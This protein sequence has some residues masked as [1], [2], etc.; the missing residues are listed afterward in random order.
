MAE[1]KD[2][3]IC[4]LI[5]KLKNDE[6]L[7]P[8]MQ[9]DFVW[10]TD[11]ICDLF[12]SILRD[13]PIGTFLFWDV[14]NITFKKY[15]FNKFLCDVSERRKG[16]LVRGERSLTQKE[17]Y[18]TVL[19]GQQRITK[20]EDDKYQIAFQSERDIRVN[21]INS[22]TNEHE[23][24][25]KISE[26]Y[27]K[28]N[29]EDFDLVDYQEE[30]ETHAA[31]NGN[32]ITWST[33]ERRNFR[34]LIERFK[35]AFYIKP[36]VNYY[37]AKNMDLGQVVEIF[38]RVNSGGQKLN[39]SDLMLSVASAAHE[40]TMGEDFHVKIQ[41]AIDQVNESTT[42]EDGGFIADQDTILTTGLMIIDAKKLSLNKE[43]N[44]EVATL[45]KMISKW[46]DII[47]SLC[48]S[49]RYYEK[50]GFE[51]KKLSKNYIM[52]VAYYLYLHKLDSDHF[53]KQNIRA[54]CDRV[55]I[56]QWTL[57]SMINGLFNYGTRNILYKIKECIKVA[58]DLNYYPL[59]RLF[60]LSANISLSISDEQIKNDIL[61][62]KYGDVRIDPLLREL[63]RDD[64][65]RKY[66]VDHIWA[67][68]LIGTKKVIKNNYPG[69][70]EED[71]GKYISYE[72]L[73]PNLQ[74]LTPNENSNKNKKYF[75]EWDEEQHPVS[76]QK[77]AY[78]TTNYIPLGISFNYDNFIEFFEKRRELLKEA[79]ESALPT[80]FDDIVA[81]YN[82]KLE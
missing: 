63:S 68:D 59:D 27:E 64:S 56:R 6:I 5:S 2:E 58:K 80:T 74:L 30:Q 35:A 26:I 77:T 1:Y 65:G 45:N 62:L 70:S 10:P 7:L 69:I 4:D 29:K 54:N 52:S 18:I 79:I 43:E 16:E 28:C 24:W 40:E 15:T 81:K 13:Y 53:D 66:S 51:S 14:D 61:S 78:Y 25:L 47:D 72:H 38:V 44:Y 20:S 46:D 73:L 75:K 48:S 12:E 22:E 8:A 60:N 42:N 76:N 57:R 19:D 21:T 32:E 23:F 33:T 17:H 49:V 11:K 34:N 36:V 37:E 82:M 67:Q 55:F 9:R 50:L 71:I 41:K 3:K 31:K 39:A